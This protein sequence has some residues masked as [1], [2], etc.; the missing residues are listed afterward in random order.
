MVQRSKE[1]KFL[2][3]SW[4]I[5]ITLSVYFTVIFSK[6]LF[7]KEHQEL[8][9]L[10]PNFIVEVYVVG[11]CLCVGLLCHDI[12]SKRPS[13]YMSYSETFRFYLINRILYFL[14]WWS[15][16]NLL[17]ASKA[18][19]TAQKDWLLWTLQKNKGTAFGKDHGFDAINS[20]EAFRSKFPISGYDLYREYAER[21]T[22]GEENV[23]LPE[24]PVYVILTTGTTGSNKKFLLTYAGVWS[25]F[26][27][28]LSLMTYTTRKKD[29]TAFTVKKRLLAW[30]RNANTMTKNGLRMGLA[31][32]C[33]IK[34]PGSCTPNIAFNE[35]KNEEVIMYI[36]A[37]FGLLRDDIEHIELV[38]QGR[39]FFITLETRWKDIVEDIRTGTL[40]SDLDLT[41]EVRQNL[42]SKIWAN[43]IR[44]ARLRQE[45]SKGFDNIVPRVW[46]KV[47][48]VEMLASGSLLTPSQAL[49]NKYFP[50]VPVWNLSHASSEGTHGICMEPGDILT[51]YF[52]MLPHIAFY[53][54]IPVEDIEE[55]QPKTKL[56]NE[57][58]L[59]EE[60]E[61]CMTTLR[62]I[63]RYRTGDIIKV[64]SYFNEIPQYQLIGRHGVLLNVCAEKTTEVAF[65]AALVETVSKL[66]DFALVDYTTA[67]NSFLDAIQDATENERYYILF[68]EI[69]AKNGKVALLTEEQQDMFDMSLKAYSERYKTIREVDRL[70]Q[71]MRVVQTV[72]GSFAILKEHLLAANPRSGSGQ[73]KTPRV[74]KKE[75]DLTFMIG[76]AAQPWRS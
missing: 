3:T 33:N 14:G 20:V 19:K 56:I 26:K 18:V 64:M 30:V 59:N 71:K 39:A 13:D 22:N 4:L 65:N 67:E 5:F 48:H 73:F 51:T 8:T 32:A 40:R 62:G 10:F 23:L 36:H 50:G 70:I 46:P 28:H 17:R 55:P 9:V 44:A 60:Y 52:T 1:H 37:V 69:E 16:R 24:K 31:S 42:Q 61:M 41:T 74:L 25:F 49:Q 12:A 63:C 29:P 43:P 34:D 66:P 27:N 35:I 76:Q 58:E 11:C 15:Y 6:L 7:Q 47:H 2:L 38:F 57:L 72:P 21:A 68:I 53:E 54:F 75:A 45:F